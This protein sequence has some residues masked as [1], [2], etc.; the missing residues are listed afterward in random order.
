VKR[1]ILW[2]LLS[3][4]ALLASITS[5]CAAD[6]EATSDSAEHSPMAC[7][8][9]IPVHDL[10][11][12]PKAKKPY[13]IEISVSTIANPYIDGLIYGAA[14]A[15]ADSGVTFTVDSGTGVMDSAS[16]IRQIENAMTRR[17]DALLMRS[18][19]IP[20]IPTDW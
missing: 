9:Q 1:E 8:R 6:V 4:T 16:Q 11:G 2:N 13:K 3:T 17:P 12:S 19:S 18:L 20:R 5:A 15:A 10:T 7:D 14:L